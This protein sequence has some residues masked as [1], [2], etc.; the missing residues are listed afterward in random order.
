MKVEESTINVD[1]KGL[2]DRFVDE[3]LPRPGEF[4]TE[5]YYN[6]NEDRFETRGAAY[7]ELIRMERVRLV[8]RRSVRRLSFW[9]VVQDDADNMPT[10]AG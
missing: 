8:T 6:A 3:F 4:T 5:D 1:L 2:H 10:E 7:Q 9:K